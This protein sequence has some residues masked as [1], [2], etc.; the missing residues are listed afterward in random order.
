M[1]CIRSIHGKEF[2]CHCL[3]GSALRGAAMQSC[4]LLAGTSL[5]TNPIL[6]Q[7]TP[8]RHKAKILGWAD[9]PSHGL[10]MQSL[11]HT[12]KPTPLPSSPPISCW[13]SYW[14]NPVRSQITRKPRQALQKNQPPEARTEWK[15]NGSGGAKGKYKAHSITYFSHAFHYTELSSVYFTILCFPT[16]E[17]LSRVPVLLLFLHFHMWK[18]YMI[19]M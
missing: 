19:F 14:L 3:S 7:R 12:P 2:L 15:E 8:D 9:I 6:P 5:L 17:S 1:N 4:V 18:I 11:Y 13:T 16:L 10:W